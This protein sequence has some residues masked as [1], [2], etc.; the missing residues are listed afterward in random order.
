MD[1]RRTLWLLIALLLGQLLLLAGQVP[2]PGG[3]SRLEAAAVRLVAPVAGTLAGLADSFSSA[4]EGLKKR[5]TLN[6][7]N[8]RLR[9]EN[10]ELR[11][12][13]LHLERVEDRLQRISEALLYQPPPDGRYQLADVVYLDHGSWLRSLMLY[14]P[15]APPPEGGPAEGVAPNQPVL[16]PQGLVGRVLLVSGPWAKVQLINDRAASVG[17]MLERT[18]RQGLVRGTQGAGLELAFLPVQSD[19]RIGD[20]VVTS[21]V[22]GIYPRGILIGTVSEVSGGDPLFH[23][24]S[25]V[26]AVDFHRLEQTYIQI[27][28]QIPVL[29]PESLQTQIDGGPP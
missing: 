13:L 18:R 5:E 12:R 20:R 6:E 17:A 22:D 27:R 23:S 8:R 19:V 10:H 25:L 16:T 29:D 1:E 24:I 11:Q 3:G 21:G 2:D 14:A 7:D 4:G 28:P 26:P 9:L 15:S